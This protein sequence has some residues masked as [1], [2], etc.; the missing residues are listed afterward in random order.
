M[1]WASTLGLTSRRRARDTRFLDH[2]P[3]QTAR[4][5]SAGARPPKHNGRSDEDRRISSDHHADNDRQRK[6]PQN[7]A[8]KEVQTYDR[9]EGHPAG[10]NRATERLVDTLVHDLLNGS[11]PSA[12][13]SLANS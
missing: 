1:P 2:F 10:Q 3:T 7:G 11:A 13:Q 8:A 6:V 12:C 9:D 4:A 5:A